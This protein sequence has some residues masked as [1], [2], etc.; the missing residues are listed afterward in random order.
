[1]LAADHSRLID[2][3]MR[4]AADPE[5]LDSNTV[6]SRTSVA[7]RQHR[8]LRNARAEALEKVVQ[9]S[10][11]PIVTR[12]GKLVLF[13]PVECYKSK[14]RIGKVVTANGVSSTVHAMFE[15]TSLT[16]FSRIVGGANG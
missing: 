5:G 9:M 1:L 8:G 3:L 6:C 15:S 13:F 11:N 2:L 14:N 4:A 7:F 10:V 12:P 16:L